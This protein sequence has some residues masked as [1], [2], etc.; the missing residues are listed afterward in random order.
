MKKNFFSCAIFFAVVSVFF[1]CSGQTE[2]NYSES[3]S[4]KEALAGSLANMEDMNLFLDAVNASLDSVVNMEGGILRTTGESP[5]SS[6][7]QIKDNIEAFKM[8]LARQ[9]ERIA[10]LEESLKNSDAKNSKLLKTIAALKKQLEEKDQAIVE[11]TEELE[12][13]NFDIQTLKAHVD[14][15]NTSVAQLNE[16]KKEQEEALE[17]QSDMMNEAYVLIGTKKELK[18]AGVLSGG[19][20]LKKSKLD[21]SKI[22]TESFNK[23]DIRK[24]KTF[25]IPANKYEILSQIP[26]GAYTVSKNDNTT[27]LTVTDA[28]KFWSVSNYL[29]IKY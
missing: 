29:I 11:L 19:T 25:T 13:R 8:I 15:L 22:D 4:L 18:A 26:T 3:D 14:K 6:R 21:M 9:H 28:A 2:R 5:K 23:I 1:A 27:T 7:E 16:E 12:K 10:E 20:L 17:R 24:T